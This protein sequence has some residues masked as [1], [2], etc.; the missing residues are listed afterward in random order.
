M[1]LRLLCQ[2]H[3][4]QPPL[5]IPPG[6]RFVGI[7]SNVKHSVGGPA[8]GRT[9]CAAFMAHRM[10]LE[11]MRRG[12][13]TMG[14]E[15]AGD[16]MNGYLANLD[17]DD[18]KLHFRPRLPEFMQGIDF[19]RVEPQVTRNDRDLTLN[20]QYVLTRGP[21]VFVERIDIE[22]NTR[23][24]ELY[25][26]M[27][28]GTFEAVWS[29]RFDQLTAVMDE[30]TETLARIEAARDAPAGELRRYP[31][32]HFAPLVGYSEREAVRTT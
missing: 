2:P 4:L 32:G 20:V 9:R 18:Y 3:E 30:Y 7:N 5:P 24:V 13:A 14:R 27:T 22:G 26:W 29:L 15:L 8:Y 28:S 11:S 21:R 23:T 16:P 25:T 10:I 19:L 31:G 6:V 1:L 17:P 12:G